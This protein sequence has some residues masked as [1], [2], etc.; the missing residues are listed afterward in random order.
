MWDME[1]RKVLVGVETADC[2]AAL[3]Y[4]VEDA[5]RRRCGI[6]LAH[7]AHPALAAGGARDESALVEGQLR[8]VDE[9]VLAAAQARVELLL[10]ERAPEDDEL[11]VS[12]ELT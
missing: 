10:R 6:H 3:R 9:M 5:A 8:H 1:P 7:V 11:T 4:A 2:E 12:T